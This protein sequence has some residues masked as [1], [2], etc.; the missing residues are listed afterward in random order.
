MAYNLVL[1]GWDSIDIISFLFV[2]LPN[3]QVVEQLCLQHHLVRMA[4]HARQ[5][6]LLFIIYLVIVF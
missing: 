5:F 1:M 6:I 3:L 2:S 4:A